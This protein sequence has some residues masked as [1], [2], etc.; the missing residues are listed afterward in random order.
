MAAKVIN[1][2]NL[3]LIHI[4][5]NLA[6]S[7]LTPH[8]CGANF[9]GGKACITILFATC[10]F[11]DGLKTS[12]QAQITPGA[13]DTNTIV[14]QSGN[15]INITGGTQAGAN[16]FHS[17]EKFGVEQGQVANFLSNPSIQ[18][19]FGR[20][21]GGDASVINGLIQVTGGNSN[22][23]LINPAGIVFGQGASLNVPAAFT[24]TTANGIGL[25]DKWF[26]A[27]GTN[28]YASLVG[29]PNAFV[30][31]Q[32]GTIFNAGDLAVE[33][34][35]SLTLL[36]GTV[37]NTGTLSAPSGNI[38]IGAV[39]QEKLVR[40][41]STGSLLSLELPIE[42]KAAINQQPFTPLSLPQLLT[43]GNISEA[44]GVTVENEVVKLTGSGITIPNT[45]GTVVVSNQ[46]N[47]SGRTG[48]NVNLLGDNVNLIDANI[49]ASGQVSGGT[50][51]IGGD[52]REQGTV[53]NASQIFVTQDSTINGY[54]L[55][56]GTYFIPS[57]DNITFKAPVVEY[58]TCG[59]ACD[60]DI[61]PTA[62]VDIPLPPSPVVDPPFPP[63]LDSPSIY[64]PVID[65]PLAPVTQIF[66]TRLLDSGISGN[67]SPLFQIEQQTAKLQ[68]N[69]RTNT[70][71]CNLPNNVAIAARST[72]SKIVDRSKK[73]ALSP[74]AAA[75]N[76]CNTTD[77]EKQ[78]LQLLGETTNAN[79]SK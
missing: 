70:F 11:I 45:P 16:L 10:I 31:T 24:A 34:G 60:R 14:N 3:L 77:D 22:L 32:S 27:L 47:V 74:G 78:I 46:V 49:D 12:A 56:N 41:S 62:V 54:A 36:G 1:F 2:A 52:S 23:Y 18:N 63:A 79:Q 50:V 59:S 21:T 67:N 20:V 58:P 75:N 43:G 4:K 42:T 17:F 9:V 8:K 72:N 76:P 7:P 57:G 69:T 6:F 65:R 26:N 68:L 5:N 61:V 28:D 33:S 29:T 48:G 38:T 64:S 71:A 44:T 40:I 30:F 39:P 51:K 73:G 55:T 66:P 13:N 35:Q 37:I 25:G 53:A 19:I 15:T